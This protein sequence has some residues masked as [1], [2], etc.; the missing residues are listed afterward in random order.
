MAHDVPTLL[1]PIARSSVYLLS[2]GL[3]SHQC[4]SSGSTSPGKRGAI[5]SF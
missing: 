5:H 2:F 3:G 4:Q 1:G